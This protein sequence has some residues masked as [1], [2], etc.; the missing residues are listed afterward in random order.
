MIHYF[1]ELLHPLSTR[2]NS[3]SMHIEVSHEVMRDSH[4]QLSLLS[5]E[6]GHQNT[7]APASS[8]LLTPPPTPPSHSKSSSYSPARPLPLPEPVHTAIDTTLS[9]DLGLFRPIFQEHLPGPTP[10]LVL[11]LITNAR[12]RPRRIPHILNNNTPHRPHPTSTLPALAPV[13]PPTS[14][15]DLEFLQDRLTDLARS[16]ARESLPVIS[17][18][19]SWDVCTTHRLCLRLL[20]EAEVYALVE[21]FTVEDMLR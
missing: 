8:N 18:T 14:D 21:R 17:R 16:A 13:P 12:P 7:F 1:K 15:L 5:A 4:F 11:V 3:E 2:L 20:R 10:L 9:L 19:L 6:M